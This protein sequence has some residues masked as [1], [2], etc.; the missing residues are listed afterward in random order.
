MEENHPTISPEK[1]YDAEDRLFEL[2]N[3]TLGTKANII[4]D[5]RSSIR[6]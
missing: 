4:F 3:D 6:T 2:E 5:V 1:F